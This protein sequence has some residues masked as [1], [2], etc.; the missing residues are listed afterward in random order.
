MTS[1][2]SDL[3]VAASPGGLDGLV[4]AVRAGAGGVVARHPGVLLVVPVVAAGQVEE[5][6]GLLEICARY[7]G[8]GGVTTVRQLAGRLA[9]AEPGAAPGCCLL[10]SIGEQRLAVLVHG[11]V[12]V[13][14]RSEPAGE[15]LLSGLDSL[16]WV[17][18]TVDLLA[19]SSIEIAAA[20]LAGRP[21]IGSALSPGTDTLANT[22]TD[23]LT[24]TVAES[25]VD[26]GA[27]TLAD[28]RAYLAASGGAGPAAGW[29]DLLRGVVPG[30]GAALT[31]RGASP[32]LTAVPANVSA[33]AGPA[34]PAGPVVPVVLADPDGPVGPDGPVV[35]PAPD[36][37]AEPEAQV[38]PAGPA[39]PVLSVGPSRTPAP[40]SAPGP[41]GADLGPVPSGEF[42]SVL[43]LDATP[44]DAPP[45]EPLP[46]TAE[47]DEVQAAEGLVLVDGALCSRGHFNDPDSRYCSTCGIAMLQHTLQLVS[48]PRPPLG[49]LILDDGATVS[50]AAD[51]VI[52]RK[53]DGDEDVRAGRAQ[54][55]QLT[56]RDN[57]VSRV[58]A[59][60]TLAGWR[61]LLSDCGSAN[62]TYLAPPGAPSWIPVDPR[63]PVRLLTGT[64][65]LIGGRVLVFESYGQ[66]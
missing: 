26:P 17:E 41:D 6:G 5:T 56:D 44:E 16:T 28:A 40:A 22:L 13:V 24:D 2:G 31:V 20:P 51:Y 55:L 21:P 43:L 49:V 50:L 64:K 4:L 60:V 35:P 54:A 63:A 61:V 10:T 32:A 42:E 11:G 36:V 7:G 18:R 27:D 19:L 48:R 3:G 29:L 45:A 53:P 57:A 52:G 62:G 47:L 34:V 8:A 9:G 14:L 1:A 25:V 38:A 15:L 65:V 58:H 66:F 59:R 23:S 12:D 37:V 33:P 39:R 46:V 30:V